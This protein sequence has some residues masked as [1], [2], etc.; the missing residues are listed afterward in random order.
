VTSGEKKETQAAEIR[1]LK[2]EAKRDFTAHGARNGV[3]ISLRLK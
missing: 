3:E 2:F 1:K